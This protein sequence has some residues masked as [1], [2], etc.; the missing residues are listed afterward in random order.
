MSFSKRA[1]IVCGNI[2]LVGCLL[3]AA[4]FVPEWFV[5]MQDE[6][7]LGQEKAKKLE[8]NAYE[9]TYHNFAEKLYLIADSEAQG[10]PMQV[11]QMPDSEVTDEELTEYVEHEIDIL[12]EPILDVSLSVKS[13]ELKERKLYMLY[14][15][16]PGEISNAFAGI[17]VYKLTYVIEGF[18]YDNM[19]LTFML[20]SE[21]YKLYGFHI[22]TLLSD[23]SLVS[24]SKMNTQLVNA[25]EGGLDEVLSL[26]RLIE[27]WELEENYDLEEVKG[28][29]EQFW[30]E[31][32][33]GWGRFACD[34]LYLSENR[35]AFSYPLVTSRYL[36]YTEYDVFVAKMGLLLLDEFAASEVEYDAYS[37]SEI[38]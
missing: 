10:A 16:M 25:K 38:R 1:G 6:S 19:E 3:M 17:Y 18:G 34:Y 28:E 4:F 26:D 9:L 37:K 2:L 35:M 12:L 15:S 20:D 32:K 5:K 36:L 11:V 27:Y 33:F 30:V 24:L 22:N 21:F 7:S 31:K 8:M 29:K 23:T 14:S 13:E